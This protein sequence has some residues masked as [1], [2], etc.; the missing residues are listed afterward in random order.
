M[1]ADKSVLTK[2]KLE[3]ILH[4]ILLLGTM[5]ILLF[6]IG[7]VVA[8]SMGLLWSAVMGVILI[9]SGSMISSSI[10]LRLY[11]AKLI[12]V[13]QAPEL[14][15]IVAHLSN[16]A[17]LAK[18]P[19]LYYFPSRVINAFATG[20][21]GNPHI[22]VSDGLLR[23][24]TVDELTGVLAHEISHLKHND[25]WVMNLADVLSRLTS[26]LALF[27]YLLIIVFLPFYF[28]SDLEMP[29]TALIL[30]W[31]APHLSALLQMALSRNRE[32]GADIFAAELTGNPLAL[33][34]A[35]RKIEL[36]QGRWL[37]RLIFPGRRIPQS[38]ILRTHPKLEERVKRLHALAE[39]QYKDMQPGPSF[40]LNWPQQTTRK[41]RRRVHGLWY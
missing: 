7:W 40:Y 6:A 32:Y 39:D 20:R 8:G 37:E 18:V 27:G 4:S 19:Q 16:R 12:S 24:L 15:E 33:A 34:S 13:Y 29:W 26:M 28:F 5:F 2:S 3:N 38:S 41:P 22:A 14:Y 23:A 10:I 9:V 31:V 1:M 36:Y 30:L 17:G 25:L 35:L 21:N 11:Q